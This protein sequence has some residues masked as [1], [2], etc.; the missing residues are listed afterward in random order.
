MF[1]VKMY[2]A[3]FKWFC[4]EDIEDIFYYLMESTVV[5]HRNFQI[6]QTLA[7]VKVVWM[8]CAQTF[9]MNVT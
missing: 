3:D 1:T 4:I 6:I 8:S 5:D 9:A 7:N 2:K